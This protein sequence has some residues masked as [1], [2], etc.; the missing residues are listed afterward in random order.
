MLCRDYL[1][2]KSLPPRTWQE[3]DSGTQHRLIPHFETWLCQQTN[4]CTT[5]TK[6]MT[7]LL[8]LLAVYSLAMRNTV[9]TLFAYTTQKSKLY[10]GCQLLNLLDTE[11]WQHGNFRSWGYSLLS[12][13]TCGKPNYN[14]K[15]Y[16]EHGGKKVAVNYTSQ[17]PNDDKLGHWRFHLCNR[18][19]PQDLTRVRHP[20]PDTVWKG[21][22]LVLWLFHLAAPAAWS[23]SGWADSIRRVLF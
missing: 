23:N 5:P 21:Q 2:K 7:F 13:R 10:Q 6:P 9:R 1:K 12:G 16:G 4:S 19:S 22:R 3:D 11:C 18:Y 14:Q 15:I 17:I 20:H 8:T